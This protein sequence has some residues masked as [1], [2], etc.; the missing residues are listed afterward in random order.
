MSECASIQRTYSSYSSGN[1]YDAAQ[2]KFMQAVIFFNM[3]KYQP[4]LNTLV[5][6]KSM[7][8]KLPKI[9][10]LEKEIYTAMNDL[11]SV[12]K[13]EEKLNKLYSN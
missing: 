7:N 1:N 10:M 2:I 9:Y 11:D 8:D 6:M 3:G 4:A 5:V 12:K 13:S